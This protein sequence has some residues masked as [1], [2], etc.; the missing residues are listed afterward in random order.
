[1]IPDL[2]LLANLQ[3]LPGF[4]VELR[5]LRG[6]ILRSGDRA[7]AMQRHLSADKVQ[8][9]LPPRFDPDTQWKLRALTVKI[10]VP[11]RL[12]RLAAHSAVRPRSGV[13]WPVALIALPS[14]R[15]FAYQICFPNNRH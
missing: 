1:M 14:S 7:Y 13:A 10:M 12:T 6:A 11:A 8:T 4:L 2:V 15:P 5:K 9:N 3:R